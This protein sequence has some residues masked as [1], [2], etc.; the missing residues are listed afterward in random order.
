[1]D[2]FQKM[3]ATVSTKARMSASDLLATRAYLRDLQREL[4]SSTVGVFTAREAGDS[5]A[6]HECM[7]RSRSIFCEMRGV[8]RAIR[9]G[10]LPF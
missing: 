1:M 7:D 4:A 10:V 8:E 3:M 6:Y 5:V 9:T 2:G